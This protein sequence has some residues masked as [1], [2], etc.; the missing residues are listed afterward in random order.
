MKACVIGF[1][2]SLRRASSCAAFFPALF[3]CDLVPA[4][5]WQCRGSA[6]RSVV[7]DN[8]LTKLY[9]KYQ[10]LNML[11]SRSRCVG[12]APTAVSVTLAM[13]LIRLLRHFSGH[14]YFR[15]A[16]LL[17]LGAAGPVREVF[18]AKFSALVVWACS[19]SLTTFLRA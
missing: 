8:I 12:G 11:N 13:F 14:R 7:A 18:I 9:H 5:Q 17:A 2:D 15:D 6:R 16:R 4:G 19:L 10:E 1:R 3:D